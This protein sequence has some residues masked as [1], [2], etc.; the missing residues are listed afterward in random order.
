M[1]AE[2]G[3]IV[4]NLTYICAEIQVEF[5]TDRSRARPGTSDF[6]WADRISSAN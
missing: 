1:N 5:D 6:P 4:G 2:N 3:T